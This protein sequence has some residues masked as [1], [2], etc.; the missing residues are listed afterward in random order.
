M[1]L[2]LPFTEQ[3]LGPT[4]CRL[5]C[6]LWRVFKADVPDSSELRWAAN[7]CCDDF[8]FSCVDGCEQI[9][10]QESKLQPLQKT[11]L[12]VGKNVLLLN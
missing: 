7:S 6:S 9:K 3:M 8:S 4:A 10:Q 1:G 12:A 5:D 2:G 11:L